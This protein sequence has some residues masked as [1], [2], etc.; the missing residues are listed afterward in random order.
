MP[1]EGLVCVELWVF[2]L[3]LSG[4][5]VVMGWLM[6]RKNKRDKQ[7]RQAFFASFDADELRM[8]RHKLGLVLR[9]VST[10]DAELTVVTIWEGEKR[11]PRGKHYTMSP[12]DLLPFDASRFL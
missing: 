5:G 7:E 10:D 11:V 12:N 8:I 9:V 1:S 6:R 4:L 2:V 3:F